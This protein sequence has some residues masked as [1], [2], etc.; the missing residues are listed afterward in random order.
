MKT[1]LTLA[2]VLFGNAAAAQ[3][4]GKIDVTVKQVAD[5]RSNGSFAH[6]GIIL[7]LPKV[8]SSDVAA[9]RVLL[10][11]AVDDSGR[12]LLDPEA[13]VPELEPNHSL[14][15]GIP[16]NPP[17]PATIRVNLK[18][19]DRKAAK[20]TELRGEIELLLPSKD[21]NSVAEI[22]KFVSMS[23]KSLA[24][25][26]LKANGVEIA[27]LNAAQIETEKKRRAE[28]KK[29]EL[30]EVGYSGDDLAEAVTNFL[31]SLFGLDESGLLARIK[32]PNK[33][34]QQIVFVDATGEVK[35][36]MMREEEGLIHLSTWAKPEP[37]WKMRV[38][39]KTPKNV[40]RYA[41]AVTDVAL[42]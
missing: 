13:S 41:F 40:V 23:G 26:A 38:S 12:N 16:A 17:P 11:S 21:A 37:D 32:D 15:M 19:P 4:A 14:G 9:S 27:L 30:A 5:R 18:N 20:V 31:E 22:P 24:H 8:K 6:L 3:Q 2:L 28:A 42:P 1:L 29:K 33:R 39:M 34:I 10:T 36:V 7:E 25:K 35:P